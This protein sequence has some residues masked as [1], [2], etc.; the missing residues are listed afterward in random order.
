MKSKNLLIYSTFLFLFAAGVFLIH[1]CDTTSATVNND[2]NSKVD[3]TAAGE[4]IKGVI[5]G[6]QKAINSRDKKAMI[7]YYVSDKNA[8]LV[9]P[10]SGSGKGGQKIYSNRAE[11]VD[12]LWRLF[13][14]IEKFQTTPNNDIKISYFEGGANAVLTGRNDVVDKKGN[15]SSSDWVWTV[16]LENRNNNW[17]IRSD[18]LKLFPTNSPGDM[19]GLRE[20]ALACSA[21]IFASVEMKDLDLNMVTKFPVKWYSKVETIPPV[22]YTASVSMTPTPLMSEGREVG[23]LLNGEVKFREIVEHVDLIGTTE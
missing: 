15:S 8:L 7:Q 16:Q 1:S 19:E 9:G 14:N 21:N 2:G 13:D 23:Q 5:N 10:F 22:N 3:R 17:L 4:T 6:V 12:N 18:N 20:L 11:Y